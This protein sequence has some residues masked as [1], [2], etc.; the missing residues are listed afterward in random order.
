VAGRQVLTNDAGEWLA[1]APAE[2]HQFVT[3]TAPVDGPLYARL[4]EKRFVRAPGSDRDL[5]V[6]LRGKRAYVFGAPSLH[7]LVVTLNCNYD[8][9]YCHASRAP[10]DRADCHMTVETA[11]RALDLIFQTPSPAITIEFQG[12]EPLANFP[13][14]KHVIERAL[15]KNGLARKE[16]LFSLISNLSLLTDEMLA[17]LVANRVQ[18]CSSLDGP[19]EAHNASR[20]WRGGNSHAETVA[21]VRQV[22]A[23]YRAAGLDV[24]THNVGLLF[25]PTREALARPEALVDEYVAL[26]VKTLAFRHLDPYGMARRTWKRHGFT[27]EEFLAAYFKTLEHMLRL[28]RE[29]VEISEFTASLFARKVLTPTDPN[30]MDLRSPCGATVGQIT[31]NYDGRV[32]TCDEGRMLDQMGDAAFQVGD[33]RTSSFNDLIRHPTT[34]AVLVASDLDGQP[35]CAWCVYR[36]YCGV[37]PVYNYA[38]Q[39]QIFGRQLENDR[40]RV[41]MAVCD[42]LFS[43]L[44]SNA[45]EVLP[46]FTRWAQ[47]KPQREFL[48]SGA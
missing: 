13:V 12:G 2:F 28:N 34:R 3:G 29:G 16:L 24:N 1:L 48:H 17:F 32:F 5:A 14:V 31:Y 22:Q 41:H 26:G 6:R 21:R 27:L 25:T 42:W 9:V 18:I 44:V 36:P 20:P 11:D 46:I 39:G 19:E 37:C 43:H 40:C 33:V 38:A 23:A 7:I 4:R 30:F 8:C 15:E 35:G 10:M 47:R 45:D